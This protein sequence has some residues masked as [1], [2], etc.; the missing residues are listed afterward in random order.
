MITRLRNCG[1]SI[2]LAVLTVVVLAAY[3][4]TAPVAA[5]LGGA[6]ALKAA[7]LAAGLCLIGAASALLIGDRLRGPH[8]ALA[9]LWLGMILRMGVPLTAGL[10]IHL[11]GGPLAQAGLLWY[12]VVFY[13]IT[14]TVGTILSLPPKGESQHLEYLEN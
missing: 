10:I 13:P 4:L 9:S 5:R 2:R 11:H 8:G 12:L 6:E 7:A 14:L 3:C 1:V